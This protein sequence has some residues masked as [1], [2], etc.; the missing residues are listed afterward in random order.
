MW[1]CLSPLY[2]NEIHTAARLTRRCAGYGGVFAR[3][4]G[5]INRHTRS[6]FLRLSA[7]AAVCFRR[8]HG[9]FRCKQQ[10]LDR[11]CPPPFIFPSLSRLL[12][13][14]SLSIGGRN[15]GCILR[16]PEA[17]KVTKKGSPTRQTCLQPARDTGKGKRLRCRP[18][19]PESPKHKLG[20]QCGASLRRSPPAC[21]ARKVLRRASPLPD[22][23]VGQRKR[24]RPCCRGWE[25]ATSLYVCMRCGGE[26][27]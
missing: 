27:F 4:W 7:E 22:F 1:G 12:L 16:H 19:T 6:Y 25:R 13:S 14:L 3:W 10:Q 26:C 15:A 24:P 5:S 11:P 23:W 9:D 8:V 21:G 2:H 17:R 20:V 18:F